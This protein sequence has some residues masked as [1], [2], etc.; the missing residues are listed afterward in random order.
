MCVCMPPQVC[1]F[2]KPTEEKPSLLDHGEVVTFFHEF[3]HVMHHLLS[4]T[5]FHRFSSF[6][7]EQD[8]VEAPSQMLEVRS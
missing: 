3:G 8:F 6:R 4:E 7:V 2:T 1:N 5:R